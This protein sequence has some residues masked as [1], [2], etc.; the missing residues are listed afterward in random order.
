MEIMAMIVVALFVLSALDAKCWSP[1]SETSRRKKL[2]YPV[3]RTAPRHRS[4]RPGVGLQPIW[5]GQARTST[6]SGPRWWWE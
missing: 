1:R 4:H 5:R 2:H 6:A 3:A